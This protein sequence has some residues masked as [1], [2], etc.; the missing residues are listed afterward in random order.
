[1][2]YELINSLYADDELKIEQNVDFNFPLHM[3]GSFEIVTAI[4]GEL[5][6]SIDGT[7]YSITPGH[8]VLIFPHQVHDF[9]VPVH[10]VHRLCIFSPNLVKVYSKIC[11]RSLPTSN[12]FTPDPDYL[13]RLLSLSP[14]DYLEAKGLLYCLCAEFDKTAQYVEKKGERN[15]LLSAIFAFVEENY[16][17]ECTLSALSQATSYHHVYLSKFFT[18][19]TGIS[20]SD[21]V[22]RHRINEACYA[23]QNT[24][25]TV[26]QVA[27]D[28][29]FES[30]RSF[31]RN[32][33]SIVGRTPSEY[34]ARV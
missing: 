32:F 28:C 13:S 2:L 14:E 8:A 33:K 18:R 7:E 15:E 22:K 24:D 9:R 25:K 4:E 11:Q 19:R 12:L 30:L 16:G 6:I 5:L 31:N 3:H 17:K 29:G 23:L 1:M 27:L 20:F 26:L 10:A 21:Y 34:R